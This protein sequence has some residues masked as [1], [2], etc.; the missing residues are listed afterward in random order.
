M[1]RYID[2]CI[3]CFTLS[4]KIIGPVTSC[5]RESYINR[6]M[7]KVAHNNQLLAELDP[8]DYQIQLDAAL[9]QSE[10][11]TFHVKMALESNNSGWALRNFIKSA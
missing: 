10:T 4:G 11:P 5:C 3:Y 1:S 6:I 2:L 7:R 8:A 9:S